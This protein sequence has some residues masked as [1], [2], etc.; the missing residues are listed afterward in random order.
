METTTTFWYRSMPI[1]F[2]SFFAIITLC[3]VDKRVP[4]YVD[5]FVRRFWQVGTFKWQRDLKSHRLYVL[6]ALRQGRLRLC[7]SLSL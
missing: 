7:P 3:T 5:G 1:C 4:G 2:V 6:T